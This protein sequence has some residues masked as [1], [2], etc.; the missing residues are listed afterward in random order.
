[1][2]LSFIN[3]LTLSR[4]FPLRM[5]KGSE[6]RDGKHTDAW[7]RDPAN[8]VPPAFNLPAHTA[9]LDILF[10]YGTT[11]STVGKGDAFVSLHGSWDRSTPDGYKVLRV[12]FTNGV[13]VSS[14]DFLA[15]TGP[16]ATGP[17]WPHRPVGLALTKCGGA[18]EC[19]LV[20]SDGSGQIIA[21]I[22][23]S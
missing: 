17:N 19:L 4:G 2:N 15:Y 7:C 6:V 22:A 1:L 20:T 12:Q 3:V 8:V 9:P 23:E 16:G 13:P 18:T 14:S 10:Y 5:G 11:F 21:V